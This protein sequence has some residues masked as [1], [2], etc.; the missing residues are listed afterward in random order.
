VEGIEFVRFGSEDVVR[1]KLVQRIVD[2]Y[3]EY[4]EQRAPALRE[5]R[6]QQG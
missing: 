2:A 3:N 4:A 1:H 5:A 6:R